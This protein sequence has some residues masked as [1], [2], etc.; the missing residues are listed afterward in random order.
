MTFEA[1]SGPVDLLGGLLRLV[2]ILRLAADE[3][4]GRRRLVALHKPDVGTVRGAHPLGKRRGLLAAL[5]LV[6]ISACCHFVAPS[7]DSSA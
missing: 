6:S 4:H 1:S 5:E 3:D 2:R 7:P